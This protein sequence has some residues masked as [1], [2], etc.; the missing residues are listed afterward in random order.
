MSWTPETDDLVPLPEA[1]IADAI[2]A[3]Y[4]ANR[5]PPRG[6][7]GISQLGHP[8]DRHL[9]Y[10]L[11]WAA[12]DNFDGRM[13]RLFDT[14]HREE[15]RI[16]SE[17]KRI[18]MHI[19]GANADG[20]QISVESPSG[21]VVG[22]LDGIALSG[23][24]G[25]TNTPHL[26]E[27][28]THNRKSFDRLKLLGMRTS[29]PKHYV[30]MQVYMYLIWVAKEVKRGLY[31]AVCKDNDEIY[32]ERVHLDADFGRLQLER[33][34]RIVEADLSPDRIP[35]ANPVTNPV[36]A[37]CQFAGVC[38]EKT[39]PA[40][41]CRTCVY[42]KFYKPNSLCLDAP[43]EERELTEDEERR[44]CDHHLPILNM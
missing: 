29:Q 41:S 25:A 23:V 30:Q 26:L 39:M 33:G 28:K 3:L 6:Y 36:C 38:F 4:E 32:T 19:V 44:G 2:Y 37:T 21:F 14:G 18:G 1:L 9:W 5:T 8:C 31:V 27:I 24:P 42:F 34:E 40:K 43:Y 22:H 12:P 10:Q 7:L 11:R 15:E 16:I 20:K 13:L 35:E 17:L